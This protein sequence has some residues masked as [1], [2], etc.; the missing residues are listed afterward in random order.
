MRYRTFQKPRVANLPR[1]ETYTWRA[2]DFDKGSHIPPVSDESWQVIV[3]PL[4]VF[5]AKDLKGC[6]IDSIVA[7]AKQ[8][9]Y[10]DNKVRH[11]LAWLSFMKLAFYD[12][13]D[14]LWKMTTL[15]A[16]SATPTEA[17]R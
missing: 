12:E 8:W 11:M 1:R 15:S 2:R 4:Q 14:N 13:S 17:E 10:A 16:R 7:W 6:P 5:M 3:R 9:G